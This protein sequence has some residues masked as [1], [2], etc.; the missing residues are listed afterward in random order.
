MERAL[1][2]NDR[3]DPAMEEEIREAAQA[4]HDES[5]DKQAKYMFCVY[6]AF[7]GAGFSRKNSFTM[8]YTY[9]ITLLGSQGV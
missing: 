5:L 4:V 7:R 6:T 8:T 3:V 1:D 2:S 9:F